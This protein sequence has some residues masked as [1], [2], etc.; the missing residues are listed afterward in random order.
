[1]FLYLHD[2]LIGG[3][4]GTEKEGGEVSCLTILNLLV[5]SCELEQGGSC[6]V[7]MKMYLGLL[8]RGL[9]RGHRCPP[10]VRCLPWP[11]SGS[12]LPPSSLVLTELFCGVSTRLL[13]ETALLQPGISEAAFVG[14]GT[15][16]SRPGGE[17]L[18][19]LRPWVGA[20]LPAAAKALGSCLALAE[21]VVE[22]ADSARRELNTCSQVV[23][24]ISTAVGYE[25]DAGAFIRHN[26]PLLKYCKLI[27]FQVTLSNNTPLLCL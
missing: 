2:E 25:K 1:M 16:G 14:G 17:A 7:Q 12:S 10:V 23:C 22:F 3:C 24:P 20:S 8:S 15:A 18:A 9:L 6:I 21:I 5:F 11:C 13:W 4:T 19:S 26:R 27:I